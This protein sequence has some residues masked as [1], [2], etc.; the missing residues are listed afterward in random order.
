MLAFL[1]PLGYGAIWLADHPGNVAFN[2]L[3]WRI[4]MAVSLFAALLLGLIILITLTLMLWFGIASW[5]ERIRHKRFHTHHDQGLQSLTQTLV[6]L[7]AS[8]YSS[9]QRALQRSMNHLPNHPALTGLLDAQLAK[10]TNQTQR[11]PRIYASLK[12]HADTRPMA[13]RGLIEHSMAEQKPEQA[14]AHIQEVLNEFPKDAWANKA[15]IDLMIAQGKLDDAT[16]QTEH[17]ARLRV[18]DA[19]QSHHLE[20]LIATLRGQNFLRD[21]RL[22]D[23][24][25]H[26]KIALKREASFLPAILWMAE[27]LDQS[28]DKSALLKHAQRCW[29]HHP[30]PR[31]T[32][33]ILAHFAHE[34]AAILERRVEQL[35]AAQ[36][37]HFES[38][39]AK[40][41]LYLRL[42]QWEKA[43]EVLNQA[44]AIRH[45][46][47]VFE[48]LAQLEKSQHKDDTKANEWLKLALDAP[49]DE[50]WICTSC[51]HESAVWHAHCPHCHT[52]D[53]LAWQLPSAPM[54]ALSHEH[55][56]A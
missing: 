22:N 51:S 42:T 26:L 38:F 29:K 33:L 27:T 2:W 32:A 10:A 8:D 23:A 55:V 43:R 25:N 18:L 7:S 9:A 30:H 36:P 1:A 11:L 39:M 17:A 16:K 6:A 45:S 31:F 24:R 20:A 5:P 3:G 12:E 4:D 52:L 54:V 13:L 14:L 21:N 48:A 46:P 19:Q 53:S 44:K 40:S 28:G 15:A 41:E 35:I 49:R 37:A 34:S 50:S 47:R 56:S